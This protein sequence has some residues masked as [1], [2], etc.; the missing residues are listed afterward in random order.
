MKH[1]KQQ[2]AVKN[3]PLEQLRDFAHHPFQVQ[4]EEIKQYFPPPLCQRKSQWVH[5]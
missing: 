4:E 1:T 3:I 2:E 5:D